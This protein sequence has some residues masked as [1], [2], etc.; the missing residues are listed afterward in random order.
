MIHHPAGD[1]KC[2]STITV[3]YYQLNALDCLQKAFK[4]SKPRPLRYESDILPI[5]HCTR[6]IEDGV[7]H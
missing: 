5:G 2:H 1:M 7:G 3:S 4:A 6:L